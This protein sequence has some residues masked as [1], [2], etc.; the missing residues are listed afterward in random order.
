M[1]PITRL[2]E[3]VAKLDFNSIEVELVTLGKYWAL[4]RKFS[5]LELELFV[6]SASRLV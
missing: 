1:N 3:L 6:F 4:F 2:L 5:D